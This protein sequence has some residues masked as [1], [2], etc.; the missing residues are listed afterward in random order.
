M[1]GQ[2]D[3][4]EKAGYI[5]GT[6]SS[7]GEIGQ[8]LYGRKWETGKNKKEEKHVGL[9]VKGSACDSEE[10]DS[11]PMGSGMIKFLFQKNRKG[12]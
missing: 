9:I 4:D 3:R 8:T 5:L 2:G 12:E 7:L 1:H 6:L 10:F 11:Y